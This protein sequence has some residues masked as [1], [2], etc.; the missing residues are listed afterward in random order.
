MDMN[1]RLILKG[2]IVPC[3]KSFV[4]LKPDYINMHIISTK[5]TVFDII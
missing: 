4:A 5:T 1:I 2:S 3:K